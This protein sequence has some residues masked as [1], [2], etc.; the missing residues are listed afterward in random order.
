[1]ELNV[2]TVLSGKMA[3]R[4]HRFVFSPQANYTN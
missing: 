4:E 2:K 3:E 1:M